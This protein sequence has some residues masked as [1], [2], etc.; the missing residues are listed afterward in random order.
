MA[1]P[2][3]LAVDGFTK[4]SSPIHDAGDGP[5]Q[6][7]GE[8]IAYAYARAHAARIVISSRSLHDLEAV[9]DKIKSINSTIQTDVVEV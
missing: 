8:H 5:H 7:T 6:G 1:D 2:R 9:A 3:V 4:Q